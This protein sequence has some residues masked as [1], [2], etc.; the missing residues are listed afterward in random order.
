MFIK[1]LIRI[2]FCAGSIITIKDI[3]HDLV[4]NDEIKFARDVKYFCYFLIGI[5]IMILL[6]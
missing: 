3:V 5:I 2:A 1:N 6:N 4:N